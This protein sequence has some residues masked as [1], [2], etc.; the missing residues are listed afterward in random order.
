RI[1]AEYKRR[2]VEISPDL[3]APWQPAE[4]LSHTGRSRTAAKM[5]HRAGVFPQGGDQC[6]EIGFGALGWLGD[7]ISWGVRETDL[8]GIE[9]DPIRCKRAQDSLPA[10]DL[11]VGDAT[12]L[13]W[14]DNGFKLVIAS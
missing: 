9:L 1:N 13:P 3:Y 7:L 4:I 6:L 2:A 11:Q 10:A 5:L 14:T 12:N 8:H